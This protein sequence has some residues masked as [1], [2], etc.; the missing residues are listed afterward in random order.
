MEQKFYNDD[1]ES[2]L[3]DSTDNFR[4]YPS[5]KVWHSLYNDLH[6]ARKWPSLAVCLVLVSAVLFIGVSNNNSI[7]Q[8]ARLASLNL[9]NGNAAETNVEVSSADNIQKYRSAALS[10]RGRSF[11]NSNLQEDDLLLNI[12]E[13][14]LPF[15]IPETAGEELII[16]TTAITNAESASATR[17]KNSNSSKTAK[18]FNNSGE[19]FLVG[20]EPVEMNASGIPKTAINSTTL[21]QVLAIQTAAA[22]E[23]PWIEDYAFHNQPFSRKLKS[24][25][26]FGF[27]VTPSVGFRT[28]QKTSDFEP[29]SGRLLLSNNAA[30]QSQDLDEVTLQYPAANLEAGVQLLYSLGKNI[31][32]KTGLQ[33]NYTNYVINAHQL[34]HPTTTNLLLKD[35]STGF[36]TL[37][38]RPSLLAN[39]PGENNKKLNNNTIQLSIPVGADIKLAG[40][41]KLKWYAGASIQPTVVTSGHNYAI[42][43]DKKNYV[44]DPSLLRKWNMNTSIETFLSYKLPSGVTINAGPQFR[45]QLFSTFSD[46]Y[47]Y[48]EKLY[49][50]GLKL[51]VSTG[52]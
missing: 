49:N 3:K 25:G 20:A 14:Q 27:Y 44:E 16:A 7:N 34:E 35:I 5:R 47:N 37:V 6:P 46:Q 41:N 43:A 10:N 51:G 4:M 40:R 23:R 45:Y 42:S 30:V 12:A 19:E 17:E 33:F 8:S 29:N 21:Q 50:I 26:A 13:T 22:D 28:L 39:T 2:F 52:F 9:R 18:D 31:R 32:V 11:S 36:P 24:H 38:P 15:S 48:S 1:F